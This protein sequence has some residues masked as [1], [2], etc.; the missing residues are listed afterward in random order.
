LREIIAVENS[1]HHLMNLLVCVFLLVLFFLVAA[2]PCFIFLLIWP[3]HLPCAPASYGV[4]IPAPNAQSCRP[5]LD[6]YILCRK[7]KI[8]KKA[9]NYNFLQSVRNLGAGSA[10][11]Y[12]LCHYTGFFNHKKT[13]KCKKVQNC[14]KNDFYLII[15]KIRKNTELKW[16]QNGPPK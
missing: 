1:L 8:Q 15:N 12:G 6:V 7:I 9:N 5:S 4:V 16:E 13:K 3:S 11:K 14:T 2:A 10:E